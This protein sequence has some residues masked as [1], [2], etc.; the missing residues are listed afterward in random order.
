MLFIGLLCSGGQANFIIPISNEVKNIPNFTAALGKFDSQL[1]RP[2]LFDLYTEMFKT[3]ADMFKVMTELKTN[4]GKRTARKANT[5]RTELP[6]NLNVTVKYNNVTESHTQP[7]IYYSVIRNSTH[8]NGRLI[9]NNTKQNN[10]TYGTKF[11]NSSCILFT[12]QEYSTI[13]RSMH[14]LII[15]SIIYIV[16]K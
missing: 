13:I 6:E 11:H 7:N 4:I 3:M 12:W 9:N 16:F 8:I 14:F 2:M 1:M 15:I 5:D 10:D